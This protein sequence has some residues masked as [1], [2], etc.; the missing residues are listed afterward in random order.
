MLEISTQNSKL[1][2]DQDVREDYL[3]INN[4]ATDQALTRFKSRR[5][6]HRLDGLWTKDGLPYLAY[7][8]S[9]TS[10]FAYHFGLP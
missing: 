3:R 1:C 10:F 9:P 4:I 5:D 2:R 6:G 7:L 8:F